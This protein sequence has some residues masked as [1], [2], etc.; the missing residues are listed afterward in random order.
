[1]KQHQ[2]ATARNDQARISRHHSRC[3]RPGVVRVRDIMHDIG[4]AAPLPDGEQG[5]G[6]DVYPA[7]LR[8]RIERRAGAG[9]QLTFVAGGAESID[10]PQQLP[11][12]AAHFRSGIEMEDSHQK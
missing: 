9:Q 10:Q 3:V 5:P 11:L 7:A 8:L 1:M 6:V 2:V 12:P 4:G